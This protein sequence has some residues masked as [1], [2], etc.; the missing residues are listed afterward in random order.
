MR[1]VFRVFDT[2]CTGYISIEEMSFALRSLG[3]AKVT[4]E[5][6]KKLYIQIGKDPE[7]DESGLSFEEFRDLVTRRQ[8]MA[9]GP[10]EC[11][12]AFRV[13]D[14]DNKG[15]ISVANL[16][17]AG[18]QATGRPVPDK[19]VA[20][21]MR[22]ADTDNDGFL[23]FE[24]F[25]RAVTKHEAAPQNQSIALGG[26]MAATA[27][28]GLMEALKEA[29]QELARRDDDEEAVQGK[30]EVIAGVKATFINGFISKVE[31]R[32][33]LYEMGY[34][35]STLSDDVYDDLFA[36]QDSDKDGL[37]TMDEYCTFLVSFGEQVDGY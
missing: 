1:A 27:A 34:E 15:R 19:L 28:G 16:K 12:A 13:F 31:V 30:T 4:D 36:E 22:V 10:E 20:E 26:T 11:H 2:S 7:V 14:V 3:W 24:E 32:R 25:R 8:R 9:D 29:Q 37:L 5:E 6:V 18:L 17:A 21:I 23:S 33:A 35:Q